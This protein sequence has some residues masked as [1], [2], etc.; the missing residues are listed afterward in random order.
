MNRRTA[1]VFV[2]VLFLLVMV[3]VL[4]P[5]EVSP[6]DPAPAVTAGSL[7]VQTTWPDGLDVDVDTWFLAPGE[8]PLGYNAQN[9]ATANLL[10][11][12]LGQFN[13]DTALNYE[14]VA[15]RSLPD[16][17]YV[18]NL[19]WYRNS[20][21]VDRVECRV[22]VTLVAAGGRPAV[23]V[24]RRVTLYH[25]GEEVTIARWALRDGALV[26]GSVD[27]VHQPV[28]GATPGGY[29]TEPR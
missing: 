24:D 13:D 8:A 12:D 25:V 6:E 19:H 23:I 11:D 4:L 3:L 1:T 16:G 27:G 28:R 15:V 14:L 21:G 2:D 18:A 7:L 29:G 20:A 5:H 17:V 9:S 10:R 26:P 22:V